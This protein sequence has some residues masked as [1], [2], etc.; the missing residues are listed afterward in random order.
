MNTPCIVPKSVTK[1][2]CIFR[3]NNAIVVAL[4]V[5]VQMETFRLCATSEA[6]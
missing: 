4:G 2:C 1:G 3:S 5:G 6:I